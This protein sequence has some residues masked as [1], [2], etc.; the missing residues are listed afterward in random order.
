MMANSSNLALL[1]IFATMPQFFTR[2]H[3]VAGSVVISHHTVQGKEFRRMHCRGGIQVLPAMGS[4]GVAAPIK[5]PAHKGKTVQNGGSIT[6]SA[7]ES[8]GGDELLRNVFS[9]F[10]KVKKGGKK[11]KK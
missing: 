11:S 7:A 10:D 9:A 3:L 2:R 5:L 1:L 6:P 4:G 8:S